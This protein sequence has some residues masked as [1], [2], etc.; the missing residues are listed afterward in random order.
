MSE[1]VIADGLRTPFGRLGGALRGYSAVEL[2]AYATSRILERNGVA[3][4]EVD[5]SYFG[6]AVLAASTLVAA[7]QINIGAGLPPETPSLTVDRACCSSMTAIG[8]ATLRIRAGA[9]HVV[10]AGGV[11]SCSRTPFLQRDARWG[12]RLGDFTIEDPLQFRNPING[13]PLA[14]VTGEVAV[15]RG[16]GRDEQDDWACRSHEYFFRALDSGFFEREVAPIPSRD[17][18]DGAAIRV[19][20]SPRRGLSREKLSQLST[21]YGS[22]TVTPGN[23]PG[24]NDGA[25]VALIMSAQDAK[26]RGAEPLCRIVEH[27]QIAGA[28]DSSPYLPGQAIAKVLER[29]GVPLGDVKRIEINEAFAVMPLV[30]TQ[31]LAD[32]DAKLLKRLREITNVN[33]GAVALGHPTGAS[34][35]R[36]VMTLANALRAVGGGYGVAAICGGF[37][38][39]DA[40]LIEVA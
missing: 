32:G 40:V 14:A 10:L 6:S 35:A 36:I 3:P 19:D 30:S 13:Q 2:G 15:A 25:S 9:S 1:V 24:L 37:G 38:Q 4:Q 31:Y 8:L 17:S 5:E 29:C 28:L 12:R 11:E 33:G 34:G 39:A 27:V 23:A 16:V 26:R 21:V 7:R 20:E 22:P 18:K